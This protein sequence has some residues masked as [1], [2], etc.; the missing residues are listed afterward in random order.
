MKNR[1]RRW[2]KSQMVEKAR[3]LV[4]PV[5]PELCKKDF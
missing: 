3:K 4:V 5:V 1:G 2:V